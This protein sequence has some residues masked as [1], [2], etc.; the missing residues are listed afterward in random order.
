MNPLLTALEKRPARRAKAE[1][2]IEGILLQRRGEDQ[3]QQER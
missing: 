2:A 3:P 1:R